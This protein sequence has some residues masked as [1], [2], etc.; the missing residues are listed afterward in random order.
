MSSVHVAVA[1]L[2]FSSRIAAE[3]RAAGV[4]LI[5][6]RSAA[7][8]DGWVADPPA[9]LLVD[10]NMA[11]PDPLELISRAKALQAPA[12]VVAFL[13]HVQ[14]D[15]AARAA[16]AGADQVLPRSSFVTQLPA[17]LRGSF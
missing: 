13:S 8:S 14:R 7:A 12:R 2:I 10:L 17:L 11:T 1:D 16:E 3:A 15:L 4:S 5:W 6:V 9:V